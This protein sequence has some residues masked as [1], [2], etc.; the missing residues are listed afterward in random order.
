MVVVAVGCAHPGPVPTG[1]VTPA[2]AAPGSAPRGP[3]LPLAQVT[4]VWDWVFRSNDDQGNLRV[5]QEEWHLV[6]RGSVIEGYYDRALTLLSLDDH[7][8]RCNQ[9]LG[10]T[11]FTRV[12]VAGSVEGG[13]VHVEEV[14]FD[15][16][17][18]PCDDGSR[19]LNRYVGE[20][21]DSTLRLEWA[22]R[23]GEQTLYRRQR[24]GGPR[25]AEQVG[26]EERPP[27]DLG[28][29]SAVAGGVPGEPPAPF[30]HPGVPLHG[31]F[32]WE[33]R[34]VDA[35]GDV[36]AEREEWHVD[37]TDGAL[38]GFYVRTVKRTRE[39]GTFR[40]NGSSTQETA[41]RFELSG[42]RTGDAVVLTETAYKADP[43]PCDNGLRRLDTYRGSISDTG[44][45]LVLSWG[46]GN[47]VLRRVASPAGGPAAG[48]TAAS[49]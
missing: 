39:G 47:Q 41:V 8:F 13:R 22:D 15:A 36:R 35:E 10:I 49:P 6:Q 2:S 44:N 12:R 5:E 43:S 23:A 20:L 17:P 19:S 42:H 11:K 31:V 9:Q 38:A 48:T 25:L 34:T 4:G 27:P 45:E 46:G 30:R 18:G 21:R 24:P 14:G 7:L 33:L 16:R 29:P 40:C 37:E 28:E 32:R 3:A 26:L 1:G